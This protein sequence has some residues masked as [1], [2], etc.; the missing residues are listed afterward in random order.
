MKA[1]IVLRD[2][3]PGDYGWIISK[4]GE[5]YSQEFHFDRQFEIDIAKKI[6]TLNDNPGSGFRLWIAEVDGL[7]AGS[8][9]VSKLTEETAFA[10]FVL[11]LNK[12][13]G[14]GIAKSLMNN[15]IE[16]CRQSDFKT[17]RLETYSCLQDARELYISMGFAITES[18]RNMQ[19]YGQT[20]DREFWELNLKDP[21]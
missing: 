15:I 21:S 20:F 10:N 18:T 1:S 6:L 8:M 13:R 5:I 14:M 17:L 19:K 16:H 7:R 3:I 9:A 4:H 12:Y 2:R 11:V